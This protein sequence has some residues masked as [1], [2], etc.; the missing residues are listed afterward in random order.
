VVTL[1]DLALLLVGA[2]VAHLVEKLL[3]RLSIFRQMRQGRLVAVAKRV[4][5]S[6]A[7][8]D[9]IGRIYE[10]RSDQPAAGPTERWQVLYVHS[11]MYEAMADLELIGISK[12]Y[13]GWTGP[14]DRIER[15][16]S[17]PLGVLDYDYAVA[18]PK[19]RGNA[20]LSKADPLWSR[21]DAGADLSGA[22]VVPER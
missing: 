9:M 12:P 2:Y 13:P 17:V 14:A 5:A 6:T 4:T 3:A 8:H 21:V 1:K 20:V 16:I 10:Y 22:K 18:A 15:R 11:S 7:M 19:F